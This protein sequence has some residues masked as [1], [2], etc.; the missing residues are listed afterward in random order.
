MEELSGLIDKIDGDI[1]SRIFEGIADVVDKSLNAGEKIIMNDECCVIH[2][3]YYL[4][5]YFLF[6]EEA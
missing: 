3:L 2:G 6:Y 1:I 5:L 4:F